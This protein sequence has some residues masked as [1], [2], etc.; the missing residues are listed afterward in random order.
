MNCPQYDHHK[1]LINA[2]ANHL[3]ANAYTFPGLESY[4]ARKQPKAENPDRNYFEIAMDLYLEHEN[5]EDKATRNLKFSDGRIRDAL[6]MYEEI[7]ATS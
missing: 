2:L 6:M 3:R 1:E 7:K 5:E 4:D